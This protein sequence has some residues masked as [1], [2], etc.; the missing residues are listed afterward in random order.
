MKYFAC[1]TL[2]EKN[3]N[4]ILNLTGTTDYIPFFVSKIP[5]S[6]NHFHFFMSQKQ[7]VS[8][9]GIMPI[10]DTAVEITAFTQYEY[11]HQ[12]LFSN[13]LKNA[14]TELNQS[15]ITDI[16]SDQKLNFPFISN[17]YSHSEYLMQLKDT[18]KLSTDN[19]YDNTEIIE[20]SFPEEN[21]TEYC[22]VIMENSTALGLLKITREENSASLHHVLIRKSFRGK[23]Y[24]KRLLVGALKM[25]SEENQCN[26]L[27]HV[28]STN[29]PAVNLYR[30]T[31]FMIIQSLDYYRLHPEEQ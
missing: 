15:Y 21:S 16:Y 7:I 26:I 13:L 31:G 17:K 8:F 23:G 20:Y 25:F 29:I 18:D 1:N 28:T 4:Q 10:S 5:D 30:Q 14:L 2:S 22:Y 27:L 9:L 12:G 24:G 6:Y 19:P 3:I 11:R